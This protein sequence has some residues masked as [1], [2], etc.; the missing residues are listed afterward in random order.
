[1]ALLAQHLAQPRV[2]HLDRVF[3]VFAYLKAHS[4]SHIIFDPDNPSVDETQFTA[5]DSSSFYPDAH[6]AITLNAP[7]PGGN[8][9]LISCFN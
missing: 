9:V 3:H 4:R 6:E 1:M 5:A 7:E 8:S 2:S